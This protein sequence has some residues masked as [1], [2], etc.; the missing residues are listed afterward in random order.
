M[1]NFGEIFTTDG[2]IQALDLTVLADDLHFL[3]NYNASPVLP[4]EVYDRNPAA[5]DELFGAVSPPAHRPGAHRHE[6]PGRRGRP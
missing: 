4:R 3:P 6:R 2:R 5:Y 1:C